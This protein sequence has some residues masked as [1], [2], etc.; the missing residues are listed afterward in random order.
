MITLKLRFSVYTCETSMTKK[1]NLEPVLKQI[2]QRLIEDRR[3]LSRI[4]DRS[5]PHELR[6]FDEQKRLLESI[7]ASV[8][9]LDLLEGRSRSGEDALARG[10]SAVAAAAVDMEKLA[11]AL[12]PNGAAH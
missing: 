1:I 8:H 7:Q 4:L 3:S 2:A 11:E 10:E 12:R 9:A 6:E 5:A